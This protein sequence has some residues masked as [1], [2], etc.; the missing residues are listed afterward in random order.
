MLRGTGRGREDGGVVV[1]YSL[2]TSGTVKSSGTGFRFSSDIAK[3]CTVHFM[4]KSIRTTTEEHAL[5]DLAVIRAW[6]ECVCVCT[7]CMR[8]LRGCRANFIPST[9][10]LPIKSIKGTC[11]ELPK[12]LLH[13]ESSTRKHQ[14]HDTKVLLHVS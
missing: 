14:V 11:E 3:R 5:H 8:I 7:V 2:H 6:E 4:N 10:F 13:T 9:A 1:L 12:V